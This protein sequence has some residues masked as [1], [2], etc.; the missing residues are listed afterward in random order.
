MKLGFGHFFRAAKQHL[1]QIR[2]TCVPAI[3]M[4]LHRIGRMW[5]QRLKR[6][7]EG[8][9]GPRGLE[10]EKRLARMKSFA[11]EIKWEESRR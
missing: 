11:I 3:P 2:Y 1:L 7:K 9:V 5:K 4:E 10:G 8:T 6:S